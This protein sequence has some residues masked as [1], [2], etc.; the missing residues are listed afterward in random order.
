M[1]FPNLRVN[2]LERLFLSTADYHHHEKTKS[3]TTTWLT[4]LSLVNALGKF[5]VDPCGYPGHKTAER[6][7]TLPEDGL[8]LPWEGRVWLKPP[9]GKGNGI[10]AWLFRLWGQGNGIALVP[11]RTETEWFQRAASTAAGMLLLKKRIA[12]LTP[13]G[14]PVTGNPVGSI[15]L[16][17]GASN[18]RVLA[19]CELEGIKIDLVN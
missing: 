4:P 13:E 17:Y 10:D 2:V 3:D 6:L 11:A 15:L 1:L 12:F 5:D 7:I 8:H 9:Y 14:V 18:A 16:A 19:T